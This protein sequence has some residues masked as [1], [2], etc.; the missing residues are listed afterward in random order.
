MVHRDHHSLQSLSCHGSH[1]RESHD[2]DGG[3]NHGDHD[4]HD[5]DHLHGVPPGNDAT[6]T[7]SAVQS[8]GDDEGS[9]DCET[10][11]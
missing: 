2:H 7:N 3:G 8:S 10:C 6:A 5:D 1:V 9:V 4:D 11:R